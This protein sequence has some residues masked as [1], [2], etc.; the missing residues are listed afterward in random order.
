V[1]GSISLRKEVASSDVQRVEDEHVLIVLRERDD[2]PFRRDLQSTAAAHLHVRTLKLSDQRAVALEHRHVEAVAVAVAYQHVARVADVDAVR[3]VGDV[4]AADAVDELAVLVEHDDA[5]SLDDDTNNP[6]ST[7]QLP[8]TISSSY[9]LTTRD[10]KITRSQD[11][12]L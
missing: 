7:L 11:N 2:V 9:V 10:I 5:V 8:F 3:V 6:L 4:L 1:V 12:N